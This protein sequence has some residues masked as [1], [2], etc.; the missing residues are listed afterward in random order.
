MKGHLQAYRTFQCCTTKKKINR[1]G[2]NS[3]TINSE[4]EVVKG[5]VLFSGFLVEHNLPLS[6]TDHTAK[7]FRNMFPNSKKVNK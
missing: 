3:V 5:E 2:A 7:L 6:T 1:F 4:Q